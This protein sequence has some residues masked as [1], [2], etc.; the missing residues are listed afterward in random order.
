MQLIVSCAMMEAETCISVIEVLAKKFTT[1]IAMIHQ[2][3]ENQMTIGN[4]CCASQEENL[5]ICQTTWINMEIWES[6]ISIFAS[7]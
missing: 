5:K 7:D 4:V 6:E 2:I 3:L 1:L